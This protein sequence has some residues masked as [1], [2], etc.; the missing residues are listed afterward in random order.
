MVTRAI[1]SM[2][3]R[4]VSLLHG[5]RITL[6]GGITEYRQGQEVHWRGNE[7]IWSALSALTQKW[8]KQ[9]RT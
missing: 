7:L 1:V 4:L 5:I 6:N 2:K 9:Q 3:Y 8:G